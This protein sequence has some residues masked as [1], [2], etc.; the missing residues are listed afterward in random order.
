MIIWWQNLPQTI[1]PIA[2]TVGFISIYWYALFFIGG[3]FLSLSVAFFFIQ[4]DHLSFPQEK[5]VDLFLTLFL[6]AVI[7]AKVGYILLY[8]FPLF[9]SSPLA[10]L[11]PYDFER[12]L[13]VGMAGMSFHGGL[14]GGI[15][16]LFFF[17]KK[18][19]WSFWRTTDLISLVLPPALFFGRLGN[20]FNGELWGRT[21]EKVWG[22]FFSY[23]PSPY[24][25]RHPSSLYESF[26]EGIVLFLVVIFVRKKMPFAGALS[27]L[28]LALYA[29]IRFVLEYLR[30]PDPQ[31]GLLVN[32]YFSLGQILSLLMFLFSLLLFLWLRKKNYAIMKQVN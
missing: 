10:F 29:D 5:L 28:F 12:H 22:M 17:T 7:G 30:E 18:E 23:A 11:S 15:L 32:G 24:V 27:I 2:F 14:I 21:T 6:G 1:Q 9:L 20:F 8:N 19:K 31:I 16:M 25:L 4:R 3:F 13:W 26:F